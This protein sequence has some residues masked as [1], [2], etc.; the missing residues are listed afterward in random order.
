[1]SKSADVRVVREW[2]LRHLHEQGDGAPYVAFRWPTD[3][4]EP[5]ND[6]GCVLREWREG[7]HGEPLRMM[8]VP[9]QSGTVWC[10][11]MAYGTGQVEY[12]RLSDLRPV[13][14]CEHADEEIHRTDGKTYSVCGSCGTILSDRR[15]KERRQG[16]RRKIGRNYQMSGRRSGTGLRSG[17]DRRHD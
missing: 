17:K 10:A 6:P 8:G 1:M 7:P 3:A 12:I 11:K 14:K 2:C 5:F 9:Y 16:E 13:E 4:P 15:E